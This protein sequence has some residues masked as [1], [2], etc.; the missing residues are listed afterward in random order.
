M[1]KKKVQTARPI[2]MRKLVEPGAMEISISR[3][4]QL[5][6][7]SSSS[8]YYKPT[9]PSEFQLDVMDEIY[10]IYLEFPFYGSRKM[11][12]ELNLREWEVG[13]KMARSLMRHMDIEAIYQKPKTSK[14]HP[15]HKIYPYRLKG[16]TIDR[17]NQVWC[18]DIT[19][20]RID[21]G[22]CYLMAVMDWY[23]RRVISWGLSNTMD[24]DFC[25]R[26]LQDALTKGT[27]GIF[28]TDQ[29]SQFTST[30]FVDILL[31]NKI[32]VSMDGKGRYL[33][34]I[35]IE[36]L[37]RSVKYEDVKIK[38]YDTIIKTQVGI[39]EYITKYNFKRIHQSLGYRTPDEV[40]KDA[41]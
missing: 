3:Q 23:S 34:N 33:D 41:S 10:D 38:Q 7:I 6:G 22:W 9:E 30:A 20:I 11:S 32:V 26:V 14:P 19:Y 1:A 5:L 21:S 16:L 29:G 27:P 31:D 15:Q 4:C 18:T 2:E 28:N 12:K 24:A 13:R 40:W 39:S 37:W 8:Y 25:C 17:P 36:R 35:L